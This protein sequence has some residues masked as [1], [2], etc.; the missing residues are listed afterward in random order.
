MFSGVM[1]QVS[2]S[3]NLMDD[4]ARWLP[5]ECY[6]SDCVLPSMKLGGG[7]CGAGLLA[8]PVSERNS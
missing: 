3:D 8:Q 4:S 2:P 5:G 7:D 1:I 6:S